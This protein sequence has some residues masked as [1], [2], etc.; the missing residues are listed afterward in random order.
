MRSGHAGC[1]P[2]GT[3]PGRFRL[4]LGP[5]P[6]PGIP[7]AKSP[8]PAR[9]RAQPAAFGHAPAA[10]P[11]PGRYQAAAAGG[12]PCRAQRPAGRP[13]PPCLFTR[14]AC[15][16][17]A[18][19]PSSPPRT[20]PS[21]PRQPSRA[22]RGHVPQRPL[23]APVAWAARRCCCGDPGL[24]RPPSPSCPLDVQSPRLGK[25]RLRALS[26]PR[27]CHG[28]PGADKARL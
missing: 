7:R 23:A 5:Q 2:R 8:T 21:A 26:P 4:R 13:R 11:R 9:P 24:S 20:R 10:L 22:G 28:R 1:H 3:A 12:C 16:D 18:V 14:T 25:P 17:G 27:S 15:W 6:D 19:P